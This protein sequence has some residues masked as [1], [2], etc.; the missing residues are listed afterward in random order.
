MSITNPALSSERKFAIP[1]TA[2]QP[3]SE[4]TDEQLRLD[5]R[6]SAL[7][8]RLVTL[9]GRLAPVLGA[10]CEDTADSAI[11]ACGPNSPLATV[12]S[13]C[14]DRVEMMTAH[15][16]RLLAKLAL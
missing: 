6:L 3:R 11:K 2:P 15:V 14:S 8:D 10:Y 4:I 1:S 13:G 16:N 9:E 5:E 12:L 7:Y